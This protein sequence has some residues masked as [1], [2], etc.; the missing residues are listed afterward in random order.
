MLPA[1]PRYNSLRSPNDAT[2][3][4]VLLGNGSNGLEGPPTCLFASGPATSAAFV[5]CSR[6][7]IVSTGCMTHVLIQ[8]AKAAAAYET[9]A[10]WASNFRKIAARFF[11]ST[12]ISR[13]CSNC[14]NNSSFAD[15]MFAIASSRS[16]FSFS[17]FCN[18]SLATSVFS[19]GLK[20]CVNGRLAWS[21]SSCVRLLSSS[22]E[23][24]NSDRISSTTF[25]LKAPSRCL[26]FFV[27]SFSSWSNVSGRAG[28]GLVTAAELLPNVAFAAVG[29][30]NE[31]AAMPCRAF[32]LE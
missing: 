1:N 23:P 22:T 11:S 20:S 6:V 19:C 31:K 29:A 17:N 13:C 4:W 14:F 3:G 5:A 8:D 18:S 28:A 2:R 16:R 32:R 26:I 12:S 30:I 25:G 21:V 10:G 24:S 7:L 15:R 9:Q 27:V